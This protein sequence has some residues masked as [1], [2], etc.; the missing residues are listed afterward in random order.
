[1]LK[2]C[3]VSVGLDFSHKQMVLVRPPLRSTNNMWLLHQGSPGSGHGGQGSSDGGY[4]GIWKL[5]AMT[6]FS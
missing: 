5:P 6:Y 4:W 2:Q 1:M 3:P